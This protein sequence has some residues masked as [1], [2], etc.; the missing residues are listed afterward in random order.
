MWFYGVMSRILPDSRFKTR[1]RE[2]CYS[3]LLYGMT[4]GVTERPL[5]D[6]MSGKFQRLVLFPNVIF[7]TEIA[8]Y[9]NHY[10]IKEGDVVI[11]AG[12]YLGHFTIYAAK[13][14]GTKGKVL[15][16]EPIPCVYRMLLENIK[17]NGLTNVVAINKGVWSQDAEVTFDSRGSAAAI[18]RDRDKSKTRTGKIRILACSL[19]AEVARQG[20]ATV[21]LIKMDIEGAE[22][23]AVQGARRLMEHPNCHFAIASYHVVDGQRTSFALEKYFAAEGYRAITEY[24]AHLTTYAARA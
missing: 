23:E 7:T 10:T 15:A 17:L 4:C 19:D 11:D 8:G 16:F 14:V 9:E 20:L 24:P 12:A 22:I 1:V 18:V 13:R 5:K 3:H 2:F 6:G 21:D